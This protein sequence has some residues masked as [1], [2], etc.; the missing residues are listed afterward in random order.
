LR[1]FPCLPSPAD[2][3]PSG[4]DWIHGINL[5]G[6]RMMVRRDPA[7]VRLLTRNG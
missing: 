7:W 2:R 1:L 3:P 6:S 5:D 4:S